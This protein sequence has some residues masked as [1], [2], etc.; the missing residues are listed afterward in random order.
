MKLL[1]FNDADR[2]RLGVLIGDMVAPLDAL[3]AEYPTILSIIVGGPAVRPSA[4]AATKS[5]STPLMCA[6]TPLNR[7]DPPGGAGGAVER[8]WISRQL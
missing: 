2:T 5:T 7:I 8:S 1:R 4:G 6:A 3:Y